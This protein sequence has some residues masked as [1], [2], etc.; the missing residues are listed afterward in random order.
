MYL[1]FAGQG[2]MGFEALV[3]DVCIGRTCRSQLVNAR[4]LMMPAVRE[5]S[6]ALP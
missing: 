4:V 3:S 2:R 6:I 1:L 5:E